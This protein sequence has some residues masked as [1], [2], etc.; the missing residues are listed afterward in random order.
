[1]REVGDAHPVTVG[2]YFWE[3]IKLAAQLGGAFLIAK[4]TV[5]LAVKRF[6]SEKEWERQT[7]TLADMVVAL[8]EMSRINDRWMNA[9]MLKIQYSKEYPGT[10][11]GTSQ[12]SLGWPFS[13]KT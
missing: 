6:K 4:Y 9:E 5:R 10:V 2:D 1:L 13:I 3:M 11:S 7:A 12:D 8:G